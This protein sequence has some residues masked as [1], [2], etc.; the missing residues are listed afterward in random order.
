M[1]KDH[2]SP[3]QQLDYT[4]LFII[5]LLL[6]VSLISIYYAPLHNPGLSSMS[7]VRK[8]AVFY[9]IGGITIAV[10]MIIDFD[11]F[12]QLAWYLYGFGILML[13]VLVLGRLG[14][15]PACQQ[16][17]FIVE[18]YGAVSW[19][20][21]PVFSSFQPAEF[22][23]IFLIILLSHIVMKH[24][25]IY[26]DKTVEDDL[27]LLGKIVLISAVPIGMVGIQP[28]L[29]TMLILTSI[30]LS[31]IL[32]SGVRWRLLVIICLSGVLLLAVA[33]FLYI[34]FPS[35]PIFKFFG[36]VEGRF[37]GWL[38][39]NENMSNEGYQL[40]QSLKA[41]GAGQL[42][43]YGGDIGFLLVAYTDFIFSVIASKFGFLGASVVVSL[44]FLLVYRI[45]HTALET[46]DPFGSYLCTGII[47]M[48]TFQVFQNI[49]MTMQLLP[50]TGIPLPFVS[51]G[52]TALL[53]YMIA[54]GIVL[55]VRSRTRT[56]MF[57]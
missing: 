40:I 9:V 4:L 28:D 26:L 1:D 20:N 57:D 54:A 30:M 13:F 41:I 47:G 8:Q 55:N 19:F 42:Y 24:H 35:A 52:G 25:E 12:R 21:V 43:G 2:N 32:V 31:I 18:K 6:C 36:H 50:I 37:L 14:I 34:Q 56:Y 29:G 23:K 46:N 15:L 10:M 53:T 3:W 16:G 48:L 51:Y 49:G 44:F 39:P 5:F 17:C 33:I 22:M 45:I 38:W 27:R 11:R 7:L